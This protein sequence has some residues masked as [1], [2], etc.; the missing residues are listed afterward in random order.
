LLLGMFCCCTDNSNAEVDIVAAHPVAEVRTEAPLQAAVVDDASYVDETKPGTMVED[1]QYTYVVSVPKG[2]EGWGLDISW[3][4][5]VTLLITKV[6]EG[7]I[8]AWNSAASPKDVVR[9]GDR[10]IKANDASGESSALLEQLKLEQRHTLTI[11][12]LVQFEVDL[13]N[14]DGRSGLVF[15]G[16]ASIVVTAVDEGS[17]QEWNQTNRCDV[18]LR[19]GDEIVAVAQGGSTIA[20]A[21]GIRKLLQAAGAIQF[22]VRRPE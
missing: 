13:D 6:K 17:V 3:H 12:R 2:T 14:G 9:R 15:A 19:V 22:T 18:E 1:L 16:D 8:A 10:L 5:G 21:I 11:R 20:D 7:P 4:D